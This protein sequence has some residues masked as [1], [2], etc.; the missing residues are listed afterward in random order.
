MAWKAIIFDFNG[1]IV[2]DEPIHYEC[3]RRV[4][5]EEEISLSESDYWEK[6]LGFDDKG[7]IEAVFERDQK[8]IGPKKLKTLI[9]KKAS[10]YLPIIRQKLKFFPEVLSFVRKAKKG[11]HLA[12]VSG[13]LRSEIDFALAEGK[14]ADLFDVIISA[15]DTKRGKP[16]PEGFLLALAKLKSLDG[17]IR[18][19]N[20]LVLEDSQAGIQAARAVGM[21]VAALTHTY[22]ADQLKEADFV[23]KAFSEITL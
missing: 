15:D 1:L 21:V 14:V 11:R 8:K 10:L 19:K 4:L 20:C 22:E 12:I 18:P 3:F 6:Y 7:L 17:K 16:D 5:E 2:D 13:A 23:V 9:E